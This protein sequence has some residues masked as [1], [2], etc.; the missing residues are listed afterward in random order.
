MSDSAIRYVV[1]REILDSRGNP[2]VEVEVELEGGAIGRAAVP[3]GASTGKHEALE[4]RDGDKRFGGKGV[5]EGRRERAPPGALHRRPRRLRPAAHRLGDA[6]RRRHPQQ[7]EVRRQRHPRRVDGGR[8]RGRRVH[9][10]PALALPR[11]LHR[12]HPPGADDEHPQRRRPRGQRARRPGVH[13]LPGG[14][15]PLLRRAPGGRGDLPQ[16]Q[17]EPQEG[18]PRDLRR[19]RG[20]LRPAAEEQRGGPRARGRRRRRRGVQAGRGDRAGAGRRRERALRRED[21]PLPLERREPRWSFT[22]RTISFDD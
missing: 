22:R 21:P 6:R 1:A 15:R 5:L 9:V 11:R 13:G 4:L 12:L 7:V 14:L 10:H 17:G 8:S 16:A 3:S 18:G 19:R 2:T 20:R